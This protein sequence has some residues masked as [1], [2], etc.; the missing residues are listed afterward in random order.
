M[1]G[2]VTY[3]NLTEFGEAHYLLNALNYNQLDTCPII[4]R[5]TTNAHFNC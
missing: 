5:N 1:I 4:L 3:T 2:H